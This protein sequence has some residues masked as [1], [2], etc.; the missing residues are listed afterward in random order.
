MRDLEFVVSKKLETDQSEEAFDRILKKVVGAPHLKDEK[1]K[2][3]APKS[4]RSK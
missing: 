2:N 3:M 4:R 1:P